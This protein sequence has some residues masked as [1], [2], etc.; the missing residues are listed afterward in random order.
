MKAFA[1]A[2]S[3]LT[4]LNAQAA[5][6]MVQVV[7]YDVTGTP[8]YGYI[9]PSNGQQVE[10]GQLGTFN[11]IDTSWANFLPPVVSQGALTGTT[12][13]ATGA[14]PL[15]LR[16]VQG[17]FNN[18][19]LGSTATWGAGFQ[20]FARS[21]NADF[22]YYL[23][24]VDANTAFVL[25]VK[26]D[27]SQQALINVLDGITPTANGGSAL[28]SAYAG[29]T[30]TLYGLMDAYEKSLVQDS[31][32]GVVVDTK[33]GAVDLSQ[34]YANPF[35]TV[36]D[37]S[38]RM[39]SQTVDSQAALERTN[40]ASGGST[41][42]DQAI[43]QI[44]DITGNY[45][46]G[47]YDQAGTSTIGGL[48][49]KED[50]VR[51]LNTL[52]G[53]PS[54]TG[55]NT[56]F[57]QFFDHGLDFI[58]KG[59]NT[60]LMAGSDGKFGTSD[61][62][63]S[64]SKIVITLDPSD[65]L[66]S[67]G[68]TQLT[69]SRAT[70]INP[71]AA[72]KDGMFGTADDVQSPGPDGLYTYGA[73]GKYGTKDDLAKDDD[74]Y[75]PTNPQY[76]NHTSPY[77][78]Q[79]Q[80]YGSNDDVTN[81]LRE[82]VEDPKN[83][84]PNPTYIPGMRL[85]DGEQ[86]AKTWTRTNP[87]GTVE[88]VRDTLPTLNELRAYLV[89]TLR[90]DLS[91]DDISNL[92]ARD[93]QG[94]VLDLDQTKDGK[95][96]KF[97]D[98]T[99]IADMLPRLDAA[100]I[101]ITDPLG[102]LGNSDP[103][104]GF[105]GISRPATGSNADAKYVSDYLD[106]TSGRPTALGMDTASGTI[107][108]EILL[109]SIGDHYIAGD[110]RANE[111]MG[112][113]AVH[114]VWHEN[115]NW[116]IDNL[117]ESI[118]GQQAAD[119]TQTYAHQFQVDTNNGKIDGLGNYVATDG[120]T[121]T[122]NQELM[123]QEALLI[124]Q[125]EYQHVAIDQF[126]RGMTPNIPLFVMYDS[127]VNADVSVEFSQGA[128][129]YGHSQLRE[130]ID[131][132]DPNGSL[133][134]MVTHYS[135]ESS[136]LNPEGFKTV[137]ATA[138]ALGMTRQFG[139]E[140]D[141][142]ITPA[143]QQKLLGQNQDLAAINIARGRDLGLPTLNAL[144]RA[145]SGGMQGNVQDLQ[146]KLALNPGD[147]TLQQA[148]DKTISLQAGLKAY[149]S[150]SD[151]QGAMVHPDAV[152]NF[153]AAYSFDGDTQKADFIVDVNSSKVDLANLTADQATALKS[154]DYLGWTA[155]NAIS[156]A[157][158][159]ME[160]GDQG[161]E[162]IDAWNGGLAEKHVFL[163]ELG[164][165]FDAIFA[166]Q[167]SRLING[168]RFYYFWR[169][170]LGLPEP[171][172]LISQVGGEQFKDV[173]ERTT[174]AKHL[175]GNVF[176]GAD[177]Y[178]EVGETPTDASTGTTRNHKYG[179]LV[180]TLGLG[181]ASK[182][183]FST[184]NNGRLITINGKQYIYDARPDGGENPDGTASEGFNAH[185]VIGG[186]INSDYIDA[187]DGD[188]TIYGE[189][190]DD[191]LIGNA[192]ADHIYGEAGN[193][194]IDGGALPDFLDGGDGSDVIHGGDDADVLIGGKGN[195]TLFG[196][197]FTDEL[198]GNEGDDTLFCGNDVDVAHGGEG[199]DRLL[200]EEGL[201]TMDGGKGDDE[202]FGGAG[203][204]Q[205]FGGDGDDILHPG[206]GANNLNLNVDEALGQAGFNLVSYSDIAIKLDRIADLNNQN[207]NQLP[208][209]PFTNL[210]VDIQ[211]VE[212]GANNDQMIGD[213]QDNWFV[214]GGGNEIISG[215]AGD[216]VIVAD[217]AKLSDLNA[218]L[219]NDGRATHFNDLQRSYPDFTLGD[220]I[221][222]GATDILYSRSTAG[223]QDTV[224]YAGKASNF[225][226]SQYVVDGP[227]NTKN[228]VG[229]RVV[230]TTG[231]ETSAKGDLLIGVEQLV[232][233]YDFAAVNAAGNHAPVNPN[234]LPASSTYKVS[235]LF[236]GTLHIVGYASQDFA[237]RSTDP[238]SP[239]VK[240]LAS[241]EAP[242]PPANVLTASLGPTNGPVVMGSTIQWYVRTN[243]ATTGT[244]TPISAADGGAEL[245]FSPKSNPTNT[246]FPQGST[247]YATVSYFDANGILT[248]STS[249]N[250]SERMGRLVVGT[251]SNN[252]INTTANSSVTN[253]Q[254]VVYGGA[255]NDTITAGDGNDLIFGGTG[256][257]TINAGNG[258]DL[259][260]GGTGAD[261]MTG[262]SGDDTF[263]VD[264]VNDAVIEGLTGGTDLI[265]A[266]VDYDLSTASDPGGTGNTF[267]NNVENLTLVM[268]SA[269][270]IGTGNNLNNTIIGNENNNTLDG[271][272]GN[273][274]L[275]GGAGVD[276]LIGGA[277]ND[278]YHV[279]DIGDVVTE[280]NNSGADTIVSMV[281]WTLGDN[282]ENLALT[283]SGNLKATGNTLANTITGN[284]GNNTL[285][286]GAGIDTTVF[287]GSSGDLNN[288]VG[289]K[290]GNTVTVTLGD[291]TMSFAADA[292][293]SATKGFTIT[294]TRKTGLTDGTDTLSN[295]ETLKFSNG[296]LD[297]LKLLST[298][299]TPNSA[300]TGAAVPS[301]LTPTETYQLSVDTST[302]ADKD[303]IA[304][305]F[306][307]QWQQSDLNG[308]GLF[309]DIAGATFKDFMPRQA[310]VNRKLQC[311]V[312]YTDA[313]GIIE[314]V[315]SA[316]TA[317]TG[318]YFALQGSR[319][320]QDTPFA[321][322]NSNNGFLGLGLQRDTFTGTAGDDEAHMGNN[323]SA[324]ILGTLLA[325]TANG[326][327]GDDRLF[328]DAGVDILNGDNG[329][330]YLEG[331]TAN[332][333][334]NGAAGDDTIAWNVG[335]GRDIIDGGTNGASGD[336]LVI[337]G[338]TAAETWKVYAKAAGTTTIAGITGLNAASRII[339]TQQTGANNTTPPALANVISQ[340][341]NI[342]E[343]IFNTSLITTGSTTPTNGVTYPNIGGDTV[344]LIGNFNGLLNYNTIRVNGGNDGAVVDITQLGS[345]HRVVLTGPSQGNQIL[346]PTR[347]QDVIAPD[348]AADQQAPSTQSENPIDHG[349][350]AGPEAPTPIVT[351]SAAGAAISLGLSLIKNPE[352]AGDLSN[353]IVLRRLGTQQEQ[354]SKFYLALTAESLRDATIDT[355]DVTLDLGDDFFKVFKIS[356]QQIYFTDDMAVE[357]HVH[358]DGSEVRFEG[359]GLSALQ[360]SGEGIGGK[361]PIAYIALTLRDDINDRIKAKRVGDDNGFLNR[362]TWQQSLNFEVSAN[363]DQVV[364]SDLVS[365]RDLGGEDA[366]MSDE[367]HMMA[368]AAQAE[369]TTKDSFWLGSERSVLKPGETG[370]SNL[371]RSGDTLE[372][373]THWQNNGEFSFRDFTITNVDQTGVAQAVSVFLDDASST[374]TTLA[375]GTDTS[376]GGVA[377]IRTKFMVNGEAGSVL[378]TSKLGFQLDALGSYHWDTSKM[379]QF[380]Q[381][382]LITFQGD[383]NYDGAVTMKD[384]AFLNA[385]AAKGSGNARG[386]SRDVD[387]NF[388][389]E[390][391][392]DDLAILD[393]DWGRSLHQG[394]DKFLGSD[395]LSMASLTG[396]G[397]LNWDSSAFQAQ[398]TIEAKS[399]YVNPITD[400][401]GTL[402]D[403]QGF[404]DLEALIQE[405]Q[406]QYGLN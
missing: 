159:F 308:T 273:D 390:L 337:N 60:T 359:A 266:S 215:G 47:G 287:S 231:V 73:D 300:P 35:F 279:D 96:A 382:N 194:V 380:Q 384:L 317:L 34:R 316:T 172:E 396:Q 94:K 392:I 224:T 270:I 36:Y 100:H 210:Y 27:P 207:I 223:K 153:I 296:T 17:L 250:S 107:V 158:E 46:V 80:T 117:I 383:L 188:D 313:G 254:D 134:A 358:I 397:Q 378:D 225:Q 349:F 260:D 286:G 187:G 332:D 401:V 110:G 249:S 324:T 350:V 152:A 373:I 239:W 14:E 105:A 376:T 155:D 141:E 145:L 303:G 259:I 106:V 102:R 116:Q 402:V 222:V 234:S 83:P 252:T 326:G 13:P 211:G 89:S 275:D 67:K 75:G 174:G 346:G 321:S 103:L 44:Q 347:P 185:E 272:A 32:Y 123:F 214:G 138:L 387:A 244:G 33:T 277:G 302:I 165:T 9:D 64:A 136:F 87:D 398:N 343:L 204:D 320:N 170:D 148:L 339:I 119:P 68:Q 135:L 251:G 400:S 394:D 367:L 169:L 330:D 282:V 205:L 235:D 70:V 23:Q 375:P 203:P 124:N 354:G 97:T 227:K 113:T 54:L 294:D 49:F 157:F 93:G 81:L 257:D 142:M 399:N 229:L 290:N 166:D 108:G 76:E 16:T 393:A 262:G 162:R 189:G 163:G 361:T 25:R 264:D 2:G 10:L 79:S 168:D 341:V 307:Y 365:L 199:Q 132:L 133:T 391:D 118:R 318:D 128:Y 381:K 171:T 18:L 221:T 82:W 151:F 213:D 202:M 24:Q 164:P 51:N 114:H 190:G 345:D 78:D 268:G 368:R 314:S 15:G 220:N 355:L 3:D 120:K 329:N 140:I 62:Y 299:T 217:S 325:E 19:Q 240:G 178:V 351:Q 137:G 315:I 183:G 245:N 388:D 147:S 403:V 198:W 143:L 91:W 344:Q 193:D 395:Q 176:F 149:G 271:G 289:V 370:F 356:D 63:Q 247:F 333:F 309:T 372:R 181:V 238:N 53:D 115:H 230:D 90:D 58:G 248:T 336:T 85:F 197:N 29:A 319:P 200:G 50:Y 26:V 1:I 179:D 77:I 219:Q 104:N 127:G 335:D 182:L 352:F 374:R 146:N 161:F 362:E 121:I 126:A 195:D 285:D 186:T 92:R 55:W 56:L 243:G 95:Q 246:T 144:R 86:L 30:E 154:L 291:Y 386:Y 331:G 258:N 295:V 241:A 228:Y 293:S 45:I 122:W 284:S 363:I 369:L 357:R 160:G 4:F 216:D 52:S 21:A 37:Y 192:G 57:G 184:A 125:M 256:A 379:D 304:T 31:T 263:I 28:P 69:I 281:D 42:T 43:Y 48:Y 156:K 65:P 327:D 191:T 196:E 22:S 72:G 20:A 218:W 208:V 111:N 41:F 180:S 278:T 12:T 267:N 139:A 242:N 233:G 226:I 261:T 276:T 377:E 8:V 283:G 232:F 236:S 39:I 66:Y 38:P 7:R 173:I 301:D 150:W 269:A 305:P 109:R 129:R 406:Q 255:G 112:L 298:R 253:F 274:D 167:M 280:A 360:G 206:T 130:T 59:G 201:D 348:L 88:E 311:V 177:S 175:V 101:L 288:I 292:K 209:E 338:A 237:A 131:T 328:G 405:Q 6:P 353:D 310:Q 364:F 74:I 366:L 334:I 40:A 389:G 371:I 265:I 312:S 98:H 212:G 61:D 297:V 306:S 404:Q 84:G 5:V 323:G 342:E 71:L 385:G 340:A 322:N 99:L 11:L